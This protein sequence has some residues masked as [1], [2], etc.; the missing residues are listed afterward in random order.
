M[1]QRKKVRLAK[2]QQTT[3]AISVSLTIMQLGNMSLPT[4][5]NYAHA[6][7]VLAEHEQ[8]NEG[9]TSF[10]TVSDNSYYMTFSD[11][12]VSTMNVDYSNYIVR[13]MPM[14][15]G[16]P[17]NP[18]IVLSFNSMMQLGR[19]GE[20]QIY[21]F[22]E[23][24]P[25]KRIIVHDG[26]LSGAIYYWSSG[27]LGQQMSG[28][29]T[30]QILPDL[31]LSQETDYYITFTSG[32]FVDQNGEGID[33][34]PGPYSWSFRTMDLTAP[35]LELS[36]NNDGEIKLD[37]NEHIL[38]NTGTLEVWDETNGSSVRIHIEAASG[39]VY[40]GNAELRQV[41]EDKYSLNVFG[42]QADHTYSVHISSGMFTDFSGNGYGG[43]PTEGWSFQIVDTNQPRI[44]EVAPRGDDVSLHP[45]L[46]I[47][48]NKNMKLGNDG[49][50]RLYNYSDNPFQPSERIIIHNGQVSGAS[51]SWLSGH[52]AG[53]L[54]G[55]STVQIVPREELEWDSLYYV[56]V[57]S[58]A[59]VD[60]RGQ[61]MNDLMNP[62][63]WSFNTLTDPAKNITVPTATFNY[64]PYSG[65][66]LR[67]SED[68]QVHTGK[69]E[70]RDETEQSKVIGTIKA[71][72]GEILYGVNSS[73]MIFS[74]GNY[75][76]K[77]LYPIRSPNLKDGH[78]YSV[79]ISSGMFKDLSGNF[80]DGTRNQPWSFK[81]ADD[82]EPH[83]VWR[84]PQQNEWVT[85]STALSF[86]FNEAI[87]LGNKGEIVIHRSKDDTIAKRIEIQ[88]G[89]IT[90]E[91]ISYNL[92]NNPDHDPTNYHN[93]V[94]NNLSISMY[95]QL[96]DN[97]EFY[98]TATSGAI[99]DLNG[100]GMRDLLEPRSW[101][102]TTVDENPPTATFDY[103]T[104][105]GYLRMDFNEPVQLGEGYLMIY[106]Q[107]TGQSVASISAWDHGF[108]SGQ[109]I[110]SGKFDSTH[111]SFHILGLEEGHQYKLFVSDRMFYDMSW[112]SYSGTGLSGWMFQ[113]INADQIA[114]TLKFDYDNASEIIL[115]FSEIVQLNNGTLE[116]RDETDHSQENAYVTA[117]SGQI[118]D[119]NS[120]LKYDRNSPYK[121]S[122]NLL[123]WDLKED[124][125]YSVHV[126]SG[127]FMDLHKNLYT[128][129][130]QEDWSF[131]VT[132]T[133]RMSRY[134]VW[135]GD[136]RAP[137]RPPIQ[138]RFSK[139]M[140][141]GQ[142]GEIQIYER[143]YSDPVQRLGIHDG[144][145]SGASFSWLTPQEV[146]TVSG[147]SSIL[148]VIPQRDL[149]YDSDYYITFSSGAF[150]D[151]VGRGTGGLLNPEIVDSSFKTILDTVQP[152]MTFDYSNYSGG[153]LR[154]SEGV[155]LN[156]GRLEVWDDTTA[157]RVQTNVIEAVSGLVVSSN[158]SLQWISGRVFLG[159]ARFSD[160]YN[161]MVPNL[162][163]DHTY[164]VHITSGMFTDFSG[165][166]YRGTTGE[167]WSFHT[168]DVTAPEVAFNYNSADGYLKFEFNES[169][170]QG[171]GY[172]KI[173][174]QETAQ[175]V[176]SISSWQSEFISGFNI[177]SSSLIESDAQF[178]IKGLK[179]GHS[180]KLIVSPGMFKDI[181]NNE[182]AGTGETGWSFRTTSASTSEPTPT[183]PEPKPD[184]KPSPSTGTSGGGGGGA[185]S[186]PVVN[187]TPQPG[188]NT[189][190]PTGSNPPA[191][192]TGNDKTNPPASNSSMLTA[193]QVAPSGTVSLPAPARVTDNT[194]IHYYDAKWDKWI[195]VPTTSDGT[196][197]KA[198]VPAGAW[199]SVMTSERNV[200]PADVVKSWAVAPVMKLMSLGIVQGDMQGNYNPK[201]AINRYEM[202]V[203]LAKTLRLDVNAPA[204]GS[205]ASS[206][207]AP[208][209]A[210]PYV[211]AVVNQGIMTGISDSFNGNG[212]V[213]REQLATLIGRMLPN[214]ATTGTSGSN[215]TFKD[216][217]KMSAWAVEGI[218]KVQAL[219][220][221]K[222]YDDQSFRPKQA[223][224]REEMAAVI[225]KV[226]DML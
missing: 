82:Q 149:K 23:S 197:I 201:Q 143:G 206:V 152:T 39:Y 68:V 215:I 20:I 162:Q 1:A 55:V 5:T 168:T 49:E 212:Q 181:F 167:G 73:N 218:A 161:L 132:D 3:K 41:K 33:D 183:T 112:H 7:E 219:G 77:D 120:F 204:Q 58:G 211:Q 101:V 62:E 75:S 104:A 140:N 87:K 155:R 59:F 188:S 130:G 34:P 199:T 89:T 57:T 186:T 79:H 139:K 210:Q 146:A 157:S 107:V 226:V 119:G 207:N 110:V 102:F 116:V 134:T 6:S 133:G 217:S 150:V 24:L 193:P 136:N 171:N 13:R 16:A 160:L 48:F 175:Q 190:A 8:Q 127:M 64:S 83:I 93:W 91:N 153:F 25:E 125:T 78:M 100:H 191:S 30:F 28:A 2:W 95:N 29:S 32:A 208:D 56:T 21:E 223:V 4:I 180:Y 122:Y 214:S 61:G 14:G 98:V 71:V 118:V 137:I 17:T 173:Y 31:N 52:T 38:L 66:L 179:E 22:G 131:H 27:L 177:D 222:G 156:T 148:E 135:T 185:P 74:N 158:A 67:F 18:T 115:N 106:D 128:G 225:A 105:S 76:A 108:V 15:P 92:E 182:Y 200:K 60:G 203:I 220:L 141:L 85:T 163:D 138:F 99:V 113:T 205:P 159:D 80:Y 65:G 178:H 124:H 103:S 45:T 165:H 184:K 44:F 221:M 172:L 121:D 35:K 216:S 72:N 209:W 151:R 19:Q 40:V 123:L 154:F 86:S 213:T 9:S 36:Y 88:D 142:Q 195:A 42:L 189:G 169:V 63:R 147:M 53:A 37:F 43:T 144:Q 51:I 81:I 176:A 26:Q 54:S 166:S 97:T 84:L 69:I 94:P 50:I 126:A 170:K 96:E 174:D 224:T 10:N 12:N 196:T 164:S 11:P 145:L 187:P 70:I 117:V 194:L 114:P 46:K 109:N 90:S 111:A 129:I 192:N 198:D 202:A 47:G